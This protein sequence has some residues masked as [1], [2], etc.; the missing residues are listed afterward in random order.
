MKSDSLV[1]GLWQLYQLLPPRRQR[2]LWAVGGLMAVAALSEMVA[3]GSALPFLA[4]LSNAPDLLVNARLQ[5]L[6]SLLGITTVPQLVVAVGMGFAGAIILSNGLRLLTLRTQQFFAAAVASDLSQEVYRRTLL[7]PYSFHVRHNSSDLIG[8]ITQD[9]AQVGGAVLPYSLLLVV[10]ALV[11]VAIATTLIAIDPLITLG[12]ACFLGIAYGWLL[13]ISKQKLSRNS[14]LISDL[15]RLLIKSLQEG[16]G[17]IREVILDGSQGVFE[18]RYQIADR[19]LRRA[20][21]SNAFIGVAPRYLI[22]AVAMSLIAALAT[23]LI[24]Q[25][26]D[27]NRIVP[28]LGTLALGANRLLPAL[29]QCFGAITAIRGTEVSLWRVI[30]ALQRPVDPVRLQPLPSPLPL[31]QTL[32][33]D[34]VWFRYGEGQAWVLQ[35]LCLQISAN[36]T[37]A[38]VGS[39]G[40][41]KSTTADLILGLLTPQK[42]QVCVDG[43]PL[44]GEQL[45]AWQRT[46]AHVPQSIFLSDGSIT[47]NIAFGIEST[48]VD[49]ERVREAAR[50]AKIAAFVEG[51]PAGY[52]TYVGERGVRLSGGQRQRIGIARALYKR[53]SV[54]VFDEATSAL[55]NATEREVMAAIEGLSGEL[56]IILIAHRL[57]TVEKCD[58]IFELNQGKVFNQGNFQELMAR[59]ATFRTY[60]PTP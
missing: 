56:T 48:A 21:A 6:W 16:L 53:A 15:S 60:L 31:E 12:A 20:G 45:Q 11:V 24:Y 47:E 43:V 9:V 25:G 14:R 22:E 28:V 42:G 51:L 54:I 37:V 10:N 8:A 18:Q 30:D 2:Q 23:V 59:S 1:Q 32:T 46:V 5:P 44:T 36:Q 29:Q 58:C 4:A 26:Q 57:T 38:F 50:L 34:R 13:R 17:G 3:L 7:Q 41:G 40:S 55:D 33:L 52:D 19:P 35:D 39:T 27:L 49:F